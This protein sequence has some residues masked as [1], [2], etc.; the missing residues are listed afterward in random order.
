[1][2]GRGY[3][4]PTTDPDKFGGLWKNRGALTCPGWGPEMF[5]FTFWNTTR[6]PDTLGFSGE[7]GSKEFF[8]DLHFTNSPNAFL[9]IVQSS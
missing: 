9:F 8:D 5:G 3:W 1:M 2:S 4:N 7:F 6:K